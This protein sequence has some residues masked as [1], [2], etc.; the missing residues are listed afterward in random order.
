MFLSHAFTSLSNIKE[1]SA[2]FRGK[3]SQN[4]KSQITAFN[5]SGMLTKSYRDYL[6]KDWD[7]I[8]FDGIDFSGKGIYQV[9]G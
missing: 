4:P 7:I 1:F 8:T 3:I 5:P 9:K 2:F 6:E